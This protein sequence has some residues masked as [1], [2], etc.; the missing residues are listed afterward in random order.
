MRVYFST[1]QTYLKHII[2][3]V[4]GNPERPQFS[5]NWWSGPRVCTS[6]G[7][8]QKMVRSGATFRRT[9]NPNQINERVIYRLLLKNGADDNN[10]S[11][12]GCIAATNWLYVYITPKCFGP[13]PLS[14]SF[15]SFYNNTRNRCDTFR[16]KQRVWYRIVNQN[17]IYMLTTHHSLF[18]RLL[19]S[20][21]LIRSEGLW[22]IIYILRCTPRA[23]F[24]K[25]KSPKNLF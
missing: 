9:L 12:G 2:I 24:L 25:N 17:F 16:S 20:A 1:P 6:V 15:L 22:K 7:L 3:D 8:H 18:A 19:G 10:W 23:R 5:R 11:I 4:H 14:C 13:G 21:W